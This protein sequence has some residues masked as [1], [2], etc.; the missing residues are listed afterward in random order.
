MMMAS[1]SMPAG[2]A[3]SERPST[4]GEAPEKS[5]VAG[6]KDLLRLV[7]ELMPPPPREVGRVVSIPEEAPKF[8]DTCPG[9]GEHAT[10]RCELVYEPRPFERPRRTFRLK[11]PF[12]R[13]CADLVAT[14]NAHVIWRGVIESVFFALFTQVHAAFAVVCAMDLV[15]VVRAIMRKS[16]YFGVT[17]AAIFGDQRIIRV[18]V[19]DAAYADALEKLNAEQIAEIEGALA[20]EARERARVAPSGPPS[21]RNTKITEPAFAARIMGDGAASTDFPAKEEPARPENAAVPRDPPG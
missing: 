2:A 4:M 9:C 3:P 6:L 16:W 1:P 15:R 19:D 8:P 10:A 13:R 18:R 21:A 7:L 5:I 20:T 12:C 17:I 11:V 14:R